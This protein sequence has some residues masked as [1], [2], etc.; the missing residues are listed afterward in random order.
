MREQ[1]GEE[2]KGATE[3]EGQSKITE[4]QDDIIVVD[5]MVDVVDD[6]IEH[7]KDDKKEDA[8]PKSKDQDKSFTSGKK[9]AGKTRSSLLHPLPHQTSAD[10][11]KRHQWTH[12]ESVNIWKGVQVRQFACV[13]ESKL[14][15]DQEISLVL[16]RL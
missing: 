2:N 5:E 3:K 12:E 10:V 11:S 15:S 16:L 14:Y 9:E 7:K 4:T 1:N 8:K 6:D 13:F